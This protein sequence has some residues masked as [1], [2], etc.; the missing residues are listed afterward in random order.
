MLPAGCGRWTEKVAEDSSQ[1]Q[2]PS[3]PIDTALSEATMVHMNQAQLQTPQQCWAPEGCLPGARPPPWSGGKGVSLSPAS[4]LEDRKRLDRNPSIREGQ[5]GAAS[6]KLFPFL[7][8]L[9]SIMPQ[10]SCL[11][12]A[13][14]LLPGSTPLEAFSI[15]WHS[16]SMASGRRPLS[17]A[18]HSDSRKALSLPHARPVTSPMGRSGHLLKV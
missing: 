4:S 11:L 13:S 15:N 16:Q 7:H 5:C 8:C 3:T 10:L 1:S 17:P 14:W 12:P 6:R 9:I 2:G 18:T